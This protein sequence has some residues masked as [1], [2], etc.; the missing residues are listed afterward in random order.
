[1]ANKELT[2]KLSF[3]P[4]LAIGISS[5]IGSGIFVS[6]S[7]VAQSARTPKLVILSWL[8]GG[9]IVLPQ[10]LI[11]AELATAYPDDGY[12]YVYINK[13]GS[14]PLAFLYGWASFLGIDPPAIT[15]YVVAVLPYIAVF[16]PFFKNAIASK[17]LGALLILL[18]ALPHLR[19]VKRGG[20]F[21]LILTIVKL[22][23]FA[24]L[25][26]L[27]LMFFKVGNFSTA[28]AATSAAGH[29][30]TG[31]ALG[32]GIAATVWSYAGMQSACYMVRRNKGS[33]EKSAKN[34]S[35][36]SRRCRSALYS[37]LRSCTGQYE[38]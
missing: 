34:T 31:A 17:L 22:L 38:Y 3:W 21:N 13:A 9:L 6:T 10:L 11:L 32:A 27:G 4:A 35:R 28:A 14:K 2:R 37:R 16:I 33:K 15:T 1:M 26:I 30:S 7:V 8:I 25:V 29:V 5:T 12:G 23:P 18:F 24:I 20:I 36:D 19:N